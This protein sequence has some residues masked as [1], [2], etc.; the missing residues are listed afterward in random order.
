MH[1]PAPI[2]L[3]VY[4]RPKHTAQTLESLMANDL[5]QESDLYVFA[6]G[7]PKNA[8]AQLLHD[9]K[10]TRKLL[11]KK[12]WC[13]NVHISEFD[14]NNGCDKIIVQGVTKIVNEFGKI[15]VLEDDI[16]TGKGFLTYMNQALDLYEKEEKV[17]SVTGYTFPTKSNQTEPYFIFG[18]TSSWG[19]ATWR[20]AWK[21]YNPNFTKRL[22]ILT[23][24]T[25]LRKKFN[26]DNSYNYYE[27]LKNHNEA[28]DIRWYA[29]VFF[30]EGY[31]LWPHESLVQNIGHDNTGVHCVE[32]KKYLHKTLAAHVP[33]KKIPVKENEKARKVAS[34]FL[35]KLES[36]GLLSRIKDKLS[37]RK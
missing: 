21:L 32:T 15:I 23:D 8:S 18:G 7:A 12:K 13:K 25:K 24:N 14:E 16:V 1:K 4:A 3:F 26:F 27:V 22:S 36:V 5:S 19:W 10:E 29:S 35:K 31:G 30:N 37:F 20:R 11:R 34:A 2:V 9:I 28:W 33:V 17:M 6:D